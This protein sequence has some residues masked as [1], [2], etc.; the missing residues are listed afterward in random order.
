MTM[1]GEVLALARDNGVATLDAQ[2]LLANLMERERGWLLAHPEA[3]L[4]GRQAS[5]FRALVER[6]A[7]GEPVAYLTG[8]REFFGL[9]FDV[10]PAVLIPRPETEHL[11]EAALEWAKPR[12]PLAIADVGTGS[13]AIAVSLA[14]HL[15]GARLVATD[16]S[17]PAL[18]VAARNAARHAVDDRIGLVQ[19]DLLRG[20]RPY[21]DLIVAN[22]PYIPSGQLADLAVARYEPHAALDGGPDGLDVVRRLLA[23]V[24]RLLA[25]DGL[26]LVEIGAEQGAA[27]TALA[28]ESW[29]GADVA[30]LRDYAGHERLLRVELRG[31]S[32]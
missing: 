5:C 32:S 20:L 17:R 24:P 16:T 8:R 3:A 18:G 22:P 13:G 2:V 11:V 7:A 23:S 4:D 1:V 26:L 31:P 21:F 14:V 10:S 28:R 30:V 15:P 27:V 19:T 6:C 12:Q 25:V 29:P 9:S